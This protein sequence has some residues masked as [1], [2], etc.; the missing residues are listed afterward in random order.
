MSRSRP[1]SILK[2]RRSLAGRLYRLAN[3]PYY[4]YRPLQLLRRLRPDGSANGEVRLVRTAWGSHLYCWPDPLGRAI[5][6]TGVYDL[7]V[8][9]T[10]TRLADS[11]ETA[12]DAGA[13]VGFMSNL[14]AHAVGPQGRVLA[15]EP[16]PEI[17]ETLNRNVSRW[18]ELEA[19]ENVRVRAAALSSAAGK[20]TLAVDPAAFAG[21]KGTASIDYFERSGSTLHEVQAT[22]L[23]DELKAPIGVL[24]LDLEGHELSA[25]EGARSLLADGLVRD[26]VFE[27]HLH[28]PTPVTE[29]LE[30]L[31]YTIVG[32]SQGLTGPVVGTPAAAYARKLWDPPTLLA[33][34]DADRAHE[35]LRRS[36]WHCLRG[37]FGDRS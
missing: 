31:G 22:R 12:V 7:V 20:L 33:T 36:G 2:R 21:N 24:K 27:E 23:D 26:I 18:R 29:L 35:R 28:P 17:L 14:L 19:I 30:S 8:T 1:E 34:R 10:L 11:G 37:H 4:Y 6:R 16:H 32:V 15:F 3:K 9:E 13:N 25:L 5:A